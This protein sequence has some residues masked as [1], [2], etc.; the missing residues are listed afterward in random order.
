MKKIEYED[1]KLKHPF[2]IKGMSADFYG[3][4]VDHIQ[5]IL[6]KHILQVVVKKDNDNMFYGSIKELMITTQGSTITDLVTDVAI[7][8]KEYADDYFNNFDRYYHSRNRRSHFPFL[9]KVVVQ[10]DVKA[11]EQLIIIA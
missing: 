11:I 8:L 2:K 10:K 9:L 5:L 3:L 7:Q 6:E 4:N 1:D